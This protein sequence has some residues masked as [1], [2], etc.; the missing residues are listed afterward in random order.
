MFKKI[1]NWF[2]RL[3]SSFKVPIKRFWYD[4]LSALDQDGDMIFMN[5]GWAG[6]Q[7][8]PPLALQP[9]DEHNRYCIQLYHRVASAVDLQDADV[10]EVG[11]GRG[12]G[13]AFIMRY[14]KPRTMTGLD[15]T[16][17]AVDFCRKHYNTPGLVFVQGN[18]EELDFEDA[19]FDAIVNVE[20]S[21]CYAAFD[22]FIAGV[23]RVLKPGGHLLF[24][25]FRLHDEVVAL[26]EEFDKNNLKVIE[27]ELL[28]P[29]ILRALKLDDQRKKALIEKK[30]P[31]LVR[32]IM[33]QF[34]ASEKEGGFG[35]M[36]RTGEMQYLRFVLQK[37]A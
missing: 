22:R 34:A 15:Y 9:E 13:A 23:S 35:E 19:R 6:E 26:R 11:S 17:R 2:T 5:Y 24:T 20:S 25:D 30:V 36:M 32:P 27:E 37:P 7:D 31:R 8:H 3:P 12:G 14:H 16:E 10:L 1:G 28:N 33:H 18:A 4:R 29:A 21:H